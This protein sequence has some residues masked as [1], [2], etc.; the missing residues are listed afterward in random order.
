[1]DLY[2]KLKLKNVTCQN[3]DLVDKLQRFVNER[4]HAYKVNFYRDKVYIYKLE[5]LHP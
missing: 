4:I 1:M 2:W 5:D 3:Q